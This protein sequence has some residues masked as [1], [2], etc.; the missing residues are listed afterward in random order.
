MWDT[1]LKVTDEQDK[2][3]LMDVDNRLVVTRVGRRR[4]EKGGRWSKRG[5]ICGDIKELK[6][7]IT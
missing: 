5:Q 3:K 1:N 4:E 6:N 7:K 2:Q